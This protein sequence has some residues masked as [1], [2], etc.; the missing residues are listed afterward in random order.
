[1][2]LAGMAFKTDG[3]PFGD[4]R[5]RLG[6]FKDVEAEKTEMVNVSWAF[7]IGYTSQQ[8]ILCDFRSSSK[9]WRKLRENAGKACWIWKVNGLSVADSKLVLES[10]RP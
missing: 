3:F 4:Y 1:M 6:R 10:W 5:E 8:L 2:S 9:I 7:Q